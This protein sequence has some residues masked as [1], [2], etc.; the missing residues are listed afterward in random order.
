MIKESEYKLRREKLA[1]SLEN[2][3]I[4]I[5]VSAK[6]KIRSNDTEYPYRQ[7]S[8]FYYLT[9]LRED[10][11]LLILRKG[12]R[13]VEST[14]FVQKRDKTQEL[15]SGK[16]LG[17]K[18][19]KKSFKHDNVFT[20][21][22]YEEKFLE[23]T[24]KSK[25]LY[26]DFGVSDE[27]IAFARDKS[28]KLSK[29]YNIATLVEQARLIKSPAEIALIKKAISITADA[30]HYA[31]QAAKKFR[32]EYEIQAGVES[33]FKHAGAYSDAYT[34][35]V[36]SGN[37]ANTLHYITN[38][39]KLSQEKL[40]LMDAGCEYKYYA[41]DITRTFPVSGKFTKAQR[42]LY[43]LVLDVEKRII[44]MVRPGVLRSSLQ[45]KAEELLCAGLIRLGILSGEL[46]KLLKKDAHKKYYPH[47][48]GHWMGIDVHDE[49]PYRDESGKEI[50]LMAG[51]VLTIEPGL[52]ID[53]CAKAAPKCYRGMGIRIEDDI[54]VTEDG[55]ENLSVAIAKEIDAIEEIAS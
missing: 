25:N 23:Y 12:K 33:I 38:S 1:L 47:G 49:A 19:A 8:N 5:I 14:L 4:A 54:L 48:I 42:E 17:Q 55:Y 27:K 13:T 35:I 34:T 16:R 3:S 39:K 26:Y 40:I 36:A 24:K 53:K 29:H 28:K 43:S 46:K 15:W 30:H 31:F 9:G 2:N 6:P 51:M 44:T 18:G 11:S 41:S 21:D 22:L 37:N 7:N 32:Y 10:N 50:P 20:I 45:K 52:Y